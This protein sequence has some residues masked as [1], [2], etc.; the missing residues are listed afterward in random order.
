[1]GLLLR[2]AVGFFVSL[3]PQRIKKQ[4]AFRSFNNLASHVASAIT[5]MVVGAV[6]FIQGLITFLDRFT[7]QV[8]Y[9]YTTAVPQSS[10]GQLMAMGA[11]GYLSY[12]A[13]PL[14]W[15]YL[16]LFIEGMLRALDSTLTS[17]HRG[18]LF[19]Y[20]LDR[21]HAVLAQGRQ[22]ARMKAL[23]G[24]PRPDRIRLFPPSSNEFIELVTIQ[25]KPWSERQVVRYGDI[26]YTLTS[27]E[28]A[29]TGAYLSYRYVFRKLLPWEIVRGQVVEL[30]T[31]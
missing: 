12:L 7:A 31:R 8:I 29:P 15:L 14:A 23:L 11:W 30:E 1:M 17:T 6:G 2:F 9:P 28:L 25:E 20:I 16:F 27:K 13:H 5:E 26:L 19:F 18:T 22:R 3:L 24:P 10:E 21:I 4:T